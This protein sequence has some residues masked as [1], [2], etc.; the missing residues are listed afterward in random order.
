MISSLKSTFERLE[1]PLVRDVSPRKMCLSGYGGANQMRSAEGPTRRD[2]MTGEHD[3]R[4]VFDRLAGCW[5]YWGWKYGAG[6]DGDSA[7][8]AL[9]MRY[10]L[11]RQMAAP[12]SPVVQ[13]GPIGHTV[14]GP[15]RT[16]IPGA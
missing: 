14:A 15:A 4:Q 11:A 7:A 16:L 9:T 8:A 6:T 10:M 12:M 1:S 13:H 2:R 3:S 5:T